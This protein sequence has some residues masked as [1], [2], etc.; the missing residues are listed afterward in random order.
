VTIHSQVHRT[1][2]ANIDECLR[3]LN[4]F[5]SQVYYAPKTRIKTKPGL[6]AVRKRIEDKKRKGEVKKMRREKF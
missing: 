4:H 2:K 1:Q 5:I 3:K 6:R